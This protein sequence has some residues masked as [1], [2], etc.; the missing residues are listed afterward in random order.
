MYNGAME[1]DTKYGYC[2]E[3]NIKEVIIVSENTS[4]VTKPRPCDCFAPIAYTCVD[5]NDKVRTTLYYVDEDMQSSILYS[6]VQGM[7]DS[8]DL[9]L[10]C[11]HCHADWSVVH[12]IVCV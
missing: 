1:M 6:N 8:D 4:N 7:I 9:R 10:A 11:V 3:R 5:E 12:E 2:A